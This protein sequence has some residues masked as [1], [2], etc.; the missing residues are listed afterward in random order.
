MV[1]QLPDG[2]VTIRVDDR[3]YTGYPVNHKLAA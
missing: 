1:A 2:R 3:I